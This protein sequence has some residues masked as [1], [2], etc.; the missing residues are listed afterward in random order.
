M[1]RRRKNIPKVAPPIGI[2]GRHAS[3]E[4][5]GLVK[6][7]VAAH[8][9]GIG[10]EEVTT[11][12]AGLRE[13]VDIV[14]HVL[15]A[16]AVEGL[17]LEEL[18]IRAVHVRVGHTHRQHG[19][20][21][22]REGRDT[23]HEDPEPG[24]GLGAGEDTAEDQAEGEEQVGNVTTGLG[25]LETGNHE[26]G[27]GRGE[28]HEGEEK[29]EHQTATL[30]DLVHGLRV[31]VETDGV[32]P[33][34]V[35]DGTHERVPGKLDND[36]GEHKDL[37]AV[38]L[39]RAL[40]DLVE[41]TLDD[42]V[43]HGL[44]DELAEDG[45]QVEDGEHL[46]LETLD[47]VGG[48]VEDETN[49][50]G[51]GDAKSGLGV[52]VRRGTPILLEDTVG[53]LAELREEGSGEFT[54][55]TGITRHFQ[56]VGILGVVL[57]TLQ[58]GL[59][60]L[61]LGAG[62]PSIVPVDLGVSTRSSTDNLK[63]PLGRVGI[64]RA[65]DT[66]LAFEVGGHGLGVL[67]NVTEVNGL[68]TLSQEE[69]TIEALE[70]HGRGLMDSAQNGLTALGEL[71]KEIQ[72]SPRSLRVETG[73]RLVNEE[74]KRRLGSKFDADCKT[75]P[76]LDV[77]AFTRDTNDG[78]GVLLHVEELNN[79]IDVSELLGAGNMGGLAE[80]STEVQG[81]TDG[82]GFEME[83]LLLNVTGLALEGGVAGLAI[84]QHLTGDDTNVDTVSE[85]V[86]KRGLTGTGNTHK[87]SQSTRLDPAVN[88]VE[89]LADFALDGN[90]VG[91]V[92]PV[93][94]A[95]LSLQETSLLVGSVTIADVTLAG[96][97]DATG[98]S[99]ALVLLE[100]SRLVTPAENENFTL[101][102]LSRHSLSGKNVSGEEEADEGE[103][104]TKVAPPVAVDVVEALLEVVISKNEILASDRTN[105]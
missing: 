31:A 83:I 58:L 54:V 56:S 92:V 2:V 36:L 30:G 82:G 62:A 6:R 78:V 57:Q 27:E 9:R 66:A 77:Q 94:D 41:R 98:L 105:G 68:T 29:Q 47:G 72:N 91:D 104:D 45:E 48:V 101:A 103:D 71:L 46:V 5:V 102:L 55:A 90:M 42:E 76:L 25:G 1:R 20:D 32:V 88:V 10:V 79:L 53:N 7:A 34:E 97:S 22:V 64:S 4:H 38:D 96:N 26:V 59:D 100:G 63:H 37:P 21:Q 23:V 60:S 81:L 11:G 84:N 67:A 70:K 13:G 69:E 51:N 8:V 12:P 50:Q 3:Q 44:L 40:T 75:L 15:G 61:I 28:P 49:E 39:G 43:R 85:T 74:K 80:E 18:D 19:A 24:H 33:A 87:S 95:S 93:E 52:D 35:H 14:G 65:L 99:I 73:S 86:E 17:E 89:N 16:G